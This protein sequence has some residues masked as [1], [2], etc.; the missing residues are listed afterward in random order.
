MSLKVKMSAVI[1][2]GNSAHL[3]KSVSSSC[4]CT[5]EF[6]SL[7]MHTYIHR[8]ICTFIPTKYTHFSAWR[9]YVRRRR[10]PDTTQTHIFIFSYF[11]S[12]YTYIHTY[13]L[14]FLPR[15]GRGCSP[16]L[17]RYLYGTVSTDYQSLTYN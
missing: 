2:V 8:Y 3:Q 9:R 1:S 10:L 11:F 12:F 16:C 4:Y 14:L 5:S 6:L 15:M 13:I 7:F 17:H